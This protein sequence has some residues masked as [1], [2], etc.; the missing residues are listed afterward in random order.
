MKKRTFL[1]AGAVAGLGLG[2][3]SPAL[4]MGAGDKRKNRTGFLLIHGSWH[5]A[6]AWTEL[7]RHLNFA[8][9]LR[10]LIR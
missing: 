4:A 6:W 5:G 1:K 3:S 8:D 7:A 9:Y 10:W 2:L